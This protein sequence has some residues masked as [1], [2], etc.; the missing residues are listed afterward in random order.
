[1]KVLFIASAILLSV[2]SGQAADFSVSSQCRK[3]IQ[4]DLLKHKLRLASIHQSSY[5]PAG[6]DGASSWDSEY[7]VTASVVNSN[8]VQTRVS[9]SIIDSSNCRVRSLTKAQ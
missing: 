1:M 6:S 5:Y 9:I 4:S 2:A 3:T 7:V 8:N